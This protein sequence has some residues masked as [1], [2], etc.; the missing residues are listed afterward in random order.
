MKKDIFIITFLS[1]ALLTSIYFIS[2][3]PFNKPIVE[4]VPQK[5]IPVPKVDREYGFAV[6]S[7]DIERFEIENNETFSVILSKLNFSKKESFDI[8]HLAKTVV[9]LRKIRTGAPYAAVYNKADTDSVRKIKYFVYEPSPVS[10]VV[11]SFDDS[12]QVKKHQR[13]LITTEEM[14]SGV[15]T[16]SLWNAMRN[17]NIDPILSIKMSDVFAWS[18]DFFGLQKG[19]KF[20]LIY[21]ITRIEGDTSWYKIGD[22]KASVFNHLDKDY[23]TFQFVV[24][25]AKGYYDKK[26][27]AMKRGFLKAPLKFSRISSKFS[28][29][30]LHPILKIRRPHHGVDY[31]APTGTPVHSVGE[32]TVISVINSRSAGKMVKIR[33]DKHYTTGYMHLSKFGSGIKQGVRVSQGQIIGYVG[34]TGLSTGPHL[35][36]RFWRNGKAIDPLKVV[37]P[38]AKPLGKKYL[39]KFKKHRD[40]LLKQLAKIKYPEV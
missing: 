7:F 22:V 18:I 1:L 34:S 24:D 5:E 27:E 11:F 25:S 31:S 26:A 21:E 29:S 6:D 17:N 23:Y 3:H 9:D 12:L 15:I 39:P 2:G 19:D 4:D 14:V 28:H 32:G 36:F 38:P 20:K 10:Y 37:G 16:T 35:D 8:S 30:R 13:K 40:K 33:H